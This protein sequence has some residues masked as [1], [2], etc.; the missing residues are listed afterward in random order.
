[1]PRAASRPGLIVRRHFKRSD[2]A[3]A[4]PF[5]MPSNNNLVFAQVLSSQAADVVFSAGFFILAEF[6]GKK[7][8]QFLFCFPFQVSFMA[9][10]QCSAF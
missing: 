9:N 10:E 8:G 3:V 2:Y 7:R 5:K 4:A 1:M 6:V